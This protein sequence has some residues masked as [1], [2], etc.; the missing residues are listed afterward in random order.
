MSRAPSLV[1]QCRYPEHS[2]SATSGVLMQASLHPLGLAINAATGGRAD[3]TSMILVLGALVTLYTMLGGIQAVIWNDVMQFCVMF[4]GL[5]ATVWISLTHVP[6]GIA[7]IWTA[8]QLAGKTS[9]STPMAVPA[10]ASWI[11]HIRLFFEQPINVVAI[12]CAIVFGR[13]AGYTSDQVMVQRFQTTKS[14]GD[15]RRAFVI[16]A[17]GDALWMFG[18]SFV[19]L[20]LLAYFNHHVLPSNLEPDKILPYFMSQA[21]PVGAVGLV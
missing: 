8:A 14:L 4:G 18:L 9:L 17:A 7:E 21:F 3:V 13:M 6:G 5:A 1:V 16:N 20:A 19:G 12:L 10:D 2:T 15:S 11:D